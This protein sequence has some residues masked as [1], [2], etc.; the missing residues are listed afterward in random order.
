LRGSIFVF[1]RTVNMNI[2][3]REITTK[4]SEVISSLS[5]QLGYGLSSSETAKQVQEILDSNDNCAFVALH[6]EK[7]IG[8]IHAFKTVRVEAKTFIE[9]GGLVVDENYRGKGVGKSLVSKVRAWCAEQKITS[10][11][12]RCNSK[13]L[14]AHQ[15]YLS[16][17]FKESKEQK[18]FEQDIL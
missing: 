15:F 12:V 2:A 13:R 10:L 14:E 5:K 7:I 16:L 9:I 11:R 18:V 3:I 17:E 8:W 6:E 1:I 4:D